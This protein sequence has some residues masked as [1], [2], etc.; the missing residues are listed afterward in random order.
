M[1]G[2]ENAGYR[3]VSPGFRHAPC[4]K[5]RDVSFFFPR[6]CSDA[7]NDGERIIIVCKS[8]FNIIGQSRWL[9]YC[10]RKGSEVDSH[11]N[12][13]FGVGRENPQCGTWNH[14]T[15]G[16]QQAPPS[17][18]RETDSWVTSLQKSEENKKK[19]LFDELY[20]GRRLPPLFNTSATQ[21]EGDDVF[22]LL[23]PFRLLVAKSK[24]FQ[25]YW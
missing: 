19:T 14:V 9:K 16:W 25:V 2:E 15:S 20:G 18:L 1:L 4:G 22:T 12:V 8:R 10:G 21:G 6:D 24:I 7:N 17:L 23:C 3:Q 11:V 5:G 13:L